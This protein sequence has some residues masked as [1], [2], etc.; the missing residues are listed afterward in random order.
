MYMGD[1][2]SRI[3]IF[4]CSIFYVKIDFKCGDTNFEKSSNQMGMWCVI[5]ISSKHFKYTHKKPPIQ[6]ELC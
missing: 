3:L 4:S 6:T 1:M 2:K 5:P